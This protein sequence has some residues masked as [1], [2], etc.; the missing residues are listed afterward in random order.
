M[1]F[2]STQPHPVITATI[3][4]I[5]PIT[6]I[7]VISPAVNAYF[8]FIISTSLTV[9]LHDS[10]AVFKLSLKIWPLK[11]W[12]YL[13]LVDFAGW[14]YNTLVYFQRLFPEIIVSGRPKIGT[15]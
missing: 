7:N 4:V 13:I 8:L 12:F 11:N 1:P 15:P 10:K 3:S 6:T 5:N 2:V 14:E 9:F